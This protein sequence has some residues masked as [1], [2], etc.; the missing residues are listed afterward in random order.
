MAPDQSRGEPG[1]SAPIKLKIGGDLQGEPIFCLNGPAAALGLPIT[2]PRVADRLNAGRNGAHRP[3][4]TTAGRDSQRRALD[5]E[6]ERGLAYRATKRTTGQVIA[7]SD[8]RRSLTADAGKKK[9]PGGGQ[10]PNPQPGSA[11]LSAEGVNQLA[12]VRGL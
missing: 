8:S 3:E 2:R 10:R 12:I 4:G 9:T 6:E 1:R 7:G 5:A 11:Y